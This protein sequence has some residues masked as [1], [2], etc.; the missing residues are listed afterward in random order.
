MYAIIL[1]REDNKVWKN[2][3]DDFFR[4]PEKVGNAVIDMKNLLDDV[5]PKEWDVAEVVDNN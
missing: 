2:Y 1:S 3:A 4:D 5:Y